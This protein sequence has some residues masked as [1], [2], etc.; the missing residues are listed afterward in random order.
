MARTKRGRGES[1]KDE[2]AKIGTPAGESPD[3]GRHRHGTQCLT[4]ECEP[5]AQIKSRNVIED[6]ED[7]EEGENEIN[8]S[9]GITGTKV[10]GGIPAGG[11]TE[12]GTITEPEKPGGVGQAGKGVGKARGK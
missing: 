2:R 8:T 6:E 10:K 5:A 1:P 9:G 7:F 4:G 11:A 12:G 3:K